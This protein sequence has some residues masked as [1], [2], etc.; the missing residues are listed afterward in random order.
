MFFAVLR[1]PAADM[2]QYGRPARLLCVAVVVAACRHGHRLVANAAIASKVL[3]VAVGFL[4]EGSLECRTSGKR[5]LWEVST[6]PHTPLP[7]QVCCLQLRRDLGIL[8]PG[9]I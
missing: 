9:M 2:H 4:D 6:Q 3:R 7:A 1:L 5:I 8:C